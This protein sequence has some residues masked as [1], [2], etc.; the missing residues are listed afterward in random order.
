MKRTKNDY[1]EVEYLITHPVHPRD[2]LKRKVKK[3][4]ENSKAAIEKEVEYVKERLMHLGDK[5]N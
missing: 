4:N 1:S 2:R 3:I 5:N